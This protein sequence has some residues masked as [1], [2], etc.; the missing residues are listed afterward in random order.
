MT[1]QP[2]QGSFVGRLGF[3]IGL[4]VEHL[5]QSMVGT[6][7]RV[8]RPLPFFR[9][10]S[11]RGETIAVTNQIPPLPPTNTNKVSIGYAK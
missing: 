9:W 1:P 10:A 4:V 6:S 2:P 7:G 5:G 11:R 8:E 3:V